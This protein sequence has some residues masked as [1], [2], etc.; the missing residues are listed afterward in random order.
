MPPKK[1]PDTSDARKLLTRCGVTADTFAKLELLGYEEAVRELELGVHEI[2][3]TNQGLKREMH[4]LN[5][6][7]V[8]QKIEIAVIDRSRAATLSIAVVLGFVIIGMGWAIFL[9]A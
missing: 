6:T 8:N 4:D 3:Q 1:Q 2:M 9:G 7:I 5:S